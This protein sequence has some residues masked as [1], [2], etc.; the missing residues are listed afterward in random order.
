MNSD[1]DAVVTW[2]PNVAII[3]DRLGNRVDIWDVQSNQ[4]LYCTVVT[5]AGLVRDQPETVTRFVDSLVQAEDYVVRNPEKAKETMR[6]VLGYDNVFME[7]VWPLHHYS[8]RLD[9]TMITAMEGQ[10]RLILIKNMTDGKE[11]P[12]ITKYIY[13]GALEAVRPEAV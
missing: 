10:T 4:P 5:E 6:Q 3:K 11:I 8:L 7:T 12:D 13:T 9:Q 1:V 2:Q